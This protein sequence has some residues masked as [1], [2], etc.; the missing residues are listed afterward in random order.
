MTTT[1]RESLAMNP[2]ARN[3]DDGVAVPS[4]G[5]QAPSSITRIDRAGRCAPRLAVPPALL[6]PASHTMTL[7][8]YR[9][10]SGETTTIEDLM[11]DA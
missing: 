9:A 3:G 11:T 8:E 7:A 4:K 10:W 2:A 6:R 5:E 1:T